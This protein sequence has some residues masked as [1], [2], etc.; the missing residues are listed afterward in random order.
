MF[1]VVHVSIVGSFRKYA[2]EIARNIYFN[3][4][5]VIYCLHEDENDS[6]VIDAD[7]Q[8]AWIPSNCL[9]KIAP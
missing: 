3:K 6:F 4:N 2:Y 9:N 1:K 8:A 7:G 5:T